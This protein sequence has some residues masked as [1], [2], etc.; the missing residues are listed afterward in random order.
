MS[1]LEREQRLLDPANNP[2][3]KAAKEHT[4][5]WNSE[6]KNP[7]EP[8]LPSFLQLGPFA[9]VLQEDETKN[10]RSPTGNRKGTL[11]RSQGSDSPKAVKGAR[12]RVEAAVPSNKSLDSLLLPGVLSRGTEIKEIPKSN[13]PTPIECLTKH[14][15]HARPANVDTSYFPG[16][17]QPLSDY[18]NA[19]H[20]TSVPPAYKMMD[21]VPTK[22][23]MEKHVW[24]AVNEKQW[25]PAPVRLQPWP[26]IT[27]V[28]ELGST[29]YRHQTE[30]LQRVDLLVQSFKRASNPATLVSEARAQYRGG[31]IL[32]NLGQ[33]PKALQR[34]EP[35]LSSCQQLGDAEGVGIAHNC[36]GVAHQKLAEQMAELH[37]EHHS[38]NTE[39]FRLPTQAQIR[40]EK[41]LEHHLKHLEIAD[42]IGQMVAHTNLGLMSASLGQRK[43]AAYSHEQAIKCSVQLSATEA[44]RAAVGNLAFLLLAEERYED[45]R[46]FLERFTAVCAALGDKRGQADGHMALGRCARALNAL[47]PAAAAF[48]FA[49]TAA[50]AAGDQA[51]FNEAK[52]ILG[53]TR[54]ELKFVH[55]SQSRTLPPGLQRPL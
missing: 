16:K 5:G 45:C 35:F 21:P 23:G 41:A 38:D 39:A 33:M 3:L 34:Y 28:P 18:P 47:Q 42:T 14:E 52:V 29:E 11:S 12:C 19:Q 31:I 40:Y 26:R 30:E 36:L 49:L 7:S 25:A 55:M 13:E 6:A 20:G 2:R 4:W 43:A 51:L 27:E 8:P 46:P 50:Q 15:W 24:G 37:K 54:G 32:E 9:S 17:V 48:E 44:E 53:I 22:F 1:R 10:K